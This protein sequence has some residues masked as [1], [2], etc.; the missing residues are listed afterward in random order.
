MQRIQDIYFGPSPLG[1]RGV[2][3]NRDI[4][5][6]EIIEICPVIVIP[7]HEVKLIHK[8]FLHDYY[9]YWGEEGNKCAIALGYGSLYNHDY[10]PNA[11]YKMD[12]ENDLLE[13]YA[14]RKI[15]SG[16]EITIT[17]NGDENDK[18]PVW[19]HQPDYKR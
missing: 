3:T 17:Y 10:D 5:E 6:G 9:F 11:M 15:K 8:S 4:E 1:G 16:D 19:F 2:F 12:F 7:K 13:I 14:L 18:S